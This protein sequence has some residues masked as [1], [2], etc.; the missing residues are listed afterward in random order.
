MI[1]N[2]NANQLKRKYLNILIIDDDVCILEIFKQ[3]LESR[4]HK[5]TIVDEGTRAISKIKESAFDVVFMDYHLNNDGSPTHSSNMKE[6]FKE[7]HFNGAVLMDCVKTNKNNQTYIFA[8]T[9]DNSSTAIEE[10]KNSGMDGALFKPLDINIL[11]KLM[12]QLE[13]S[14]CTKT[15]LNKL[16]KEL[17]NVLV[18]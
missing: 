11:N 18:F 4:G 13:N 1:K 2:Y 14:N 15:L 12:L 6:S 3:Y 17:K 8:Y 5:V 10:C 7:S 9:G 16:A